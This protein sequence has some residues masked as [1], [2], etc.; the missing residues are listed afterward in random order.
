MSV[1][2]MT[3]MT[4]V[5]PACLHAK[6]FTTRRPSRSACR[7]VCR[8]SQKQVSR[9]WNHHRS[10][11][12]TQATRTVTMVLKLQVAKPAKHLA[13]VAG[14]LF[15]AAAAMQLF[16]APAAGAF[17]AACTKWLLAFDSTFSDHQ[18]LS[19]T[20]TRLPLRQTCTLGHRRPTT[21]DRKLAR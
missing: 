16:T 10:T 1:F 20:Q 21:R 17:H 19:D 7:H 18:L 2:A 5:K 8:A 9:H 15:G 12:H 14:A 13:G 4:S 6:G 11:Y 3:Q